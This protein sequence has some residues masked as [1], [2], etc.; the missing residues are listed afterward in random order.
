[1]EESDYPRSRYY[2][3][4][5]IVPAAKQLA[6]ARR[7]GHVGL[8]RP[9]GVAIA[10]TSPLG[11]TVATGDHG[12]AAQSMV[13]F[14]DNESVVLDERQQS[15]VEAQHV[16]QFSARLAAKP[17]QRS[18]FPHATNAG[19]QRPHHVDAITG[20]GLAR[21]NLRLHEG[22]QRVLPDR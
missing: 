22:S 6:V 5:E 12:G 4:D 8:I 1:M 17:L 21:F 20:S 14:L 7:S 16:T 3:G 13:G 2:G 15:A 18:G 19:G 10:N 11:C 9:D